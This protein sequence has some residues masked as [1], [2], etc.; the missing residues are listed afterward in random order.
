MKYKNES[1]ADCWALFNEILLTIDDKQI[2][3]S[4]IN[5]DSVETVPYDTIKSLLYRDFKSSPYSHYYGKFDNKSYTASVY[6]IDKTRYYFIVIIE[7]EVK[8]DYKINLKGVTINNK[9]EDEE[10]NE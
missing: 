3:A 4:D 6:A 10:E 8:F 5:K 1:N 9:Y 7:I 2:D